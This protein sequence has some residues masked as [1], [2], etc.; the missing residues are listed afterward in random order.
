M[1]SILNI[2]VALHCEAA[3]IIGFFGLKKIS[4]KLPFSI[5]VNREKTIYLILSGVGKIKMSAATAFLYF[6][7]G[8]KQGTSFLNIGIAGSAEI[9]LGS[10]V[11]ANKIIDFS[12]GRNNYPFIPFKNLPQ[13]T[14][15]TH[16][17]S[18]KNFPST[19]MIDMEG[20]AFFQT[21]ALFVTQEQIQI[22]KIISDSHEKSFEELNKSTVENL[23]NNKLDQI[24][25]VCHYLTD[26]SHHE[27]AL[28]LNENILTSFQTNWHFTHSQTEQLREYLRRW[29]ILEDPH[30]PL[31]FCQNEKNAADVIKKLKSKL[32]YANCLY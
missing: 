2:I 26:L 7:T 30:D 15:I 8:R 32:D 29:F 27:N 22:I 1:H 6:Y 19:G 11:L 23:I 17:L 4:E 10:A 9:S 31:H 5:F 21:A 20:S 28:E 25:E 14:L 16:D 12:T 3:P 24:K 13:T 18:Q